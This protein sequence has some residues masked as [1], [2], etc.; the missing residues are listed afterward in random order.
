MQEIWKDIEG[1]EGVY[2]ISNFGNIKKLN[3]NNS[4]FS[5][6]LHIIKT[7]KDYYKIILDNKIFLIHRLVAETFIPNPKNKPQVNHI[8]GNKTNNNVTNL[9]WCTAQ[10]NIIHAYKIGLRKPIYKKGFE[11]EKNRKVN[12][13]DLQGN[14]LNSYYSIDY[15]K[16]I[17]GKSSHI[18]ECCQGKRKQ[19]KGYIWKYAD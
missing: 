17:Y 4:G 12:Q 14:F 5:K 19:A 9:E 2:Q 8:D 13:Y 6:K 11:S 10:E 3:Y 15:A 1:Y 18:V 7:K 16:S